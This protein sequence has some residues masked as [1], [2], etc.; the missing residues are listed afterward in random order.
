MAAPAAAPADRSALALLGEVLR[1][2][3]DHAFC[4]GLAKNVGRLCLVHED[5]HQALEHLYL[6]AIAHNTQVNDKFC[7]NSVAVTAHWLKVD[8]AGWLHDC[9]VRLLKVDGI[10]V[11][12]CNL[13]CRKSESGWI[14]LLAS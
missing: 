10:G 3:G 12:N 4:G 11:W 6:A 5:A 7:W 9:N 13:T 8:W 14:V 2:R 1:E